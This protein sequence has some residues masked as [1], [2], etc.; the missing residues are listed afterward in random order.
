LVKHGD[1][2]SIAN[3]RTKIPTIFEG[4]LELYAGF[5]NFIYVFHD[6]SRNPGWEKLDRYTAH[7]ADVYDGMM[8][9]ETE[10]LDRYTAHTADVYDGMMGEETETVSTWTVLGT[11]QPREM[12][13]NITNGLHTTFLNTG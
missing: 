7:T 6:F 8:G 10:T 13:H 9:E 11:G 1:Y 12:G 3:C 2:S 5:Q 4:Y